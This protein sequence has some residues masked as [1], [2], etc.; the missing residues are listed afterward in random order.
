MRRSPADTAEMQSCVDST[1]AHR[2][3]P[4]CQ[5]DIYSIHRSGHRARQRRRTVTALDFFAFVSLTRTC[6]HNGKF[7][8]PCRRGRLISQPTPFVA[9]NPCC[10]HSVPC[11]A[12]V[13]GAVVLKAYYCCRKP[14]LPV[15]TRR[16]QRKG[17]AAWRI[18]SRAPCDGRNL[19]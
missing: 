16:R 2:W 3:L 5:Y 7:S 18:A 4:I 1:T 13:A 12:C 9:K 15:N 19:G 10:A 8:P 11:T 17:Q 14:W 6:H